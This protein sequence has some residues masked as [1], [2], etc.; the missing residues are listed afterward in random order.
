MRSTSQSGIAIVARSS[1]TPTHSGSWVG[2]GFA[3]DLHG[4]PPGAHSEIVPS[5][6]GVAFACGRWMNSGVSLPGASDVTGRATNPGFATSMSQHVRAGRAFQHSVTSSPA[7]AIE[8]ALGGEIPRAG[9][10]SGPRTM[11]AGALAAGPAEPELG[12]GSVWLVADPEQ[13]TRIAETHDV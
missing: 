6:R 11:H 7:I 13:A 4:D 8:S 9:S 5:A 3:T 1:L 2:L 10:R 12:A